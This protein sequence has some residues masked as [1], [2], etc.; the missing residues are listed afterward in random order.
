MPAKPLKF[1]ISR[2]KKLAELEK[3][4]ETRSRARAGQS[5]DTTG[6]QARNGTFLRPYERATDGVRTHQTTFHVRVDLHEKLRV[7]CAR[8]GKHQ[9]E[10][11]NEMLE[12]FF[13]T[14]ADK[15]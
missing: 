2:E 6:P 14:T 3:K 7:H 15:S 11:I 4:A 10:I 1:A 13:K 8:A 12:K 5:S 9:S